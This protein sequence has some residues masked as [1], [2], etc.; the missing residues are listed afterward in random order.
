[1]KANE[2]I[3]SVIIPTYNTKKFVQQAVDSVLNQTFKNC[4][5][6]LVDN[7]STDGSYEM[8]QS[9][10]ADNERV[11][12]IHHKTNQ[13]VASSR[14]DGIQSA[15]GKYI[16]FLDSDDIFLPRA[17]ETFFNIAE[18]YQ[19]E[20]VSSIGYLMSKDENIEEDILNN[21]RPCIE[22][23][24]VEKVTLLPPPES[25]EYFQIKL[26]DYFNCVYG[27]WCCWNK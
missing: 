25:P 9:L 24:P 21:A 6:I 14:N 8:C 5:V 15:R 7:C 13:G 12:L 26:N 27:W 16:A 20:V 18:Q 23:K 19:A 3:I 17:L 2:P 10:Y 11:N 4:E 1:M 22:E